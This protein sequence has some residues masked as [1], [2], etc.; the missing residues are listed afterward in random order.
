VTEAIFDIVQQAIISPWGYLVLFAV[1]AIDGFFPVIPSESAIIMAGVFA[2]SGEPDLLLVILVSALGAFAGDQVSYRIGRIAGSRLRARMRPGTRRRA[3]FDRAGRLLAKRGG[4]ILVAARYI[5]GG[6]TAT[7]MMMGTI[8]YRLRSFSLFAAV[9]AL[10]WGTYAA[11]LGYLGGRA[12]EDDP[13]KGLLLGFG[14]AVA[15]TVL[16]EMAR[17]LQRRSG[18][19]ADAPE[20]S[21]DDPIAAR[22]IGTW[23]SPTRPLNLYITRRTMMSARQSRRAR[24]LIAG[25]F[26]GGAMVGTL[27]A[28]KAFATVDPATAPTQRDALPF[29]FSLP[30][31]SGPFPIG[32]TELHLVD[33]ARPDPWVPGKTRELMVSVWYPARRGG[34]Q[35]TTPYMQPGAAA[36]F[37]QTRSPAIG[38]RPGQVD[39]AGVTTHA[40]TG[41]PVASHLGDRPLVLYSPGGGNARTTGTVLV[42]QLASRGYVVVTVDHTHE[43]SEVEFPGGRVEVAAIPGQGTSEVLK[44]MLQTRVADVGFVLDQ[45]AALE[46]GRNPDAERRRLPRGLGNLLDL[47]RIGMFGHS[48]GGFTAAETM[49]GDPRIDAGI[50]LDGSMG[51]N[52]PANDFGEVARRGLDRPFMLMGA[53]TSDP[54][55]L[56]HT[57]H[58]AP[59][60]RSFWDHS[61]GWKLDLYVPDGEHFTFIDLQAVL[62]Q[63]DERFGLPAEVIAGAIGTVDPERIVTSLRAYVPAFFDEHLRHRPQ[64]LLDGPS[65]R[66]PDIHF[67]R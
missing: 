32:T 56:P 48:I 60:W 8:G 67:I 29:R 20:G 34:S 31:P 63:L 23:I 18:R 44:K 4:V 7:T 25:L 26:L 49:L 21:A 51:F 17:Y 2:A 62:P 36:H 35:P 66:H 54:G 52:L 43:A 40:R 10:S 46:A 65:P 50:D 61:T 11:L 14:I 15:A 13:V 27:V 12:F 37:D 53:G 19:D 39:W 5:P 57:H 9:A 64:R 16:V 22:P 28:P 42:E 55:D 47:S 24:R 33:H 41:A 45:L 58:N 59:D 1:A 3:S 6:R 30:V 38:L